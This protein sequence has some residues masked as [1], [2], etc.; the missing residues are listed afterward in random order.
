MFNYIPER[1]RSETADTEE[2]AAR[3]LAG[4]PNARRPPE[5][6]TR[7][8]VARAINEEVKAGRGSKHGGA[9]LNIATQRSAEDIKKKLPS[10]YHQFK[11]LAELDITKEPMEVGP[12]CHYFMGGIRVDADTSM[13]SIPGL[14]ACGECA[15]GMHG[16]N[17]LGG[18]SLS[19]LLVFGYLS[20]K[21]A[22]EFAKNKTTHSEINKDQASQ[23]IRNA[24]DI[25]NR[26][27]GANPYLLH[28]QLEKNMQ[29]NVGI[30]RTKEDLEKGIEQLE[31][32]KK[33][34][35]TV[36]AKGSSQFN[37]GWHEALGMRKLL[38]TA[39]AVA[40]AAILREESRG[41]HTRA[42]FPGEQKEWL[43]YNI[44]SKKGPDGNMELIKVQRP[45]PDPELVRIAESSI[46]DLENEIAE[47]RKHNKS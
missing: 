16:A 29:V 40:R 10:M 15:A 47:E 1:F 41:A 46:E 20:G 25:L 37:P 6:L 18:N 23:I 27:S 28:E 3:W 22:S 5:L 8:V 21:N 24:T 9:Y 2:E 42:D 30:I 45:K 35:K 36:K 11:V 12:T 39:E 38:I 14:F 33:E 43:N 19:D 32:L 13:S 17:R 31:S 34:Y 44:I 4:D 26:E 7:D